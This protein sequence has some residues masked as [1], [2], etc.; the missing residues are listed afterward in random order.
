MK[1]SSLISLVL[2]TTAACS[3]DEPGRLPRVSDAAP[4]TVSMAYRAAE[5][6]SFP[7]SVV[8]ERTAEV[9]TRMSGT[10]RRVAVEVGASVREGDLLLSLDDDDVTARVRAA[11]AA[12]TLAELTFKRMR[13]LARDGAASR[14]ELDRATAAL[15]ATRSAEA[16]VRAQLAYTAVR[17]PFDG[18][19]SARGVDAGDLA[20]PGMPLFTLVS[21]GRVKV[22]ADLPARLAGR[23]TPGADVRV[24]T[25][26]GK[27]LGRVARV[28]PALDGASHTFR[29]EV[30]VPNDDA[31]M[32][33]GAFARL[34]LDVG[35]P[36]S[37]WL[38]ADAIVRRGQLEGVYSVEDGVVRLRWLRLGRTRGESVE[39]LSGPTGALAVVRRPASTLS[40]GQP[41]GPVALEPWIGVASGVG[42]GVAG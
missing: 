34:A 6:E 14:Q 22:V 27:T 24:T 29:V 30:I 3:T 37:M 5:R 39:V 10:V 2:L 4:V 40:D 42:E 16:G 12:R 32:V 1:R 15:E 28:V 20:V 23:V 8:A 41:V 25:G 31:S 18:V 38:P 35:A 7:A 36:A 9:A 19:V 13:N 26:S 21:H 11:E 17:A 33:P